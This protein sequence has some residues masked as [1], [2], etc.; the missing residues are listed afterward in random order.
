MLGKPA[1]GSSPSTPRSRPVNGRPGHWNGREECRLA[2]ARNG[3]KAAGESLSRA[4]AQA[5]ADLR[6]LIA[7]FRQRGLS[8]RSIAEELNTLGHT[9]RRGQCWNPVQ[10]SRILDR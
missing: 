1:P 4:A 6:P 3:A 2:G 5:Y 7:E 10:V 8:L 9:T